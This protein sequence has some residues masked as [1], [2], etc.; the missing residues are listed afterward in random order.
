MSIDALTDLEATPVPAQNDPG[1]RLAA[2]VG[3]EAE[4]NLVTDGVPLHAAT[5]RMPAEANVARNSHTSR[6]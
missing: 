5:S 4:A 6:A 2:G 3:S 1:V